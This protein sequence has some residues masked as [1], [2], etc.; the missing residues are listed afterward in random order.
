MA[1]YII[2]GSPNIF[3]N[4]GTDDKV[5]PQARVG[6]L[7]IG[8]CGHTGLIISGS[9]DIFGNIGTD[10]KVIPKAFVGSLVYGCNIGLVISGDP[11]HFLDPP[12]V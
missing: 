8:E 2:S 5:I 1:G 11:T 4:I 6:D 12:E 3:S 9:P 7:T 10:D